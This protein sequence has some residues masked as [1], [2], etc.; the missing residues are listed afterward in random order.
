MVLLIDI[1][2]LVVALAV[3]AKASEISISSATK[4]SKTVGIAEMAIGFVLLAVMTSLPELSVVIMSGLSGSNLGVATLFGSNVADVALVLGVI[5]LFTVFSIPKKNIPGIEQTLLITGIIS[6]FAFFLKG[7]N[8]TF[9]I[10]GMLIFFLISYNLVKN[11]RIKPKGKHEP[12]KNFDTF[13]YFIFLF[14]SIIAVILSADFVTTSAIS[15]AKTLAISDALIGATVVAIGTSLPELAVS[16]EAVRS[17]HTQMA[18]GNITGSLLANITLILGF[19]GIVSTVV[20]DA[21]T[22]TSLLFM[23]LSYAIFY[24]LARRRNFSL[25]QGAILSILYV[26]FIGALI[27]GV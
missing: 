5:A 12:R 15:I 16:L 2:I 7:V 3:L 1:V 20:F 8:F 19:A 25:V 26:L 13:K 22:T 21:A 23:I 6:I 11:E 9:G 17:G 18:I 4:F 14:A 27:L 10:F 24:I